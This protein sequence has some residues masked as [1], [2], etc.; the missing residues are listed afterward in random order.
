MWFK[1]IFNIKL[2]NNWKVNNIEHHK[3]VLS[4]P[5]TQKIASGSVSIK[6]NVT[7]FY[8]NSK[9]KCNLEDTRSISVEYTCS[10]LTLGAHRIKIRH[11]LVLFFLLVWME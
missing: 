4:V 11:Y 2:K 7:P 9:E 6:T 3:K 1:E 5:V 10:D 8:A